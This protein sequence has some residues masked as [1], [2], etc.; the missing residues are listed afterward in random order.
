MANFFG[1]DECGSVML[2]M[3]VP[4]KLCQGKDMRLLCP[5]KNE[6]QAAVHRP[7]VYVRDGQVVVKAGDETHPMTIDHRIE[8]TFLQTSFG[9]LYCTLAEGDEP[10]AG[11]AVVP[12]EVEEVYLY[13]NVH[14]LWKAEEPV[15]P[16]DFELNT[17]ACSPEFTEG[18]LNPSGL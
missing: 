16:I 10:Q 1:C 17:V 7:R 4:P 6:A 9:G 5:T 15:L 2:E 18:C 11:F 14:G 8:W 12:G 13:C 3:G